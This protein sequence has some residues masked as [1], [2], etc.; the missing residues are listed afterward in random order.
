MEMRAVEAA[1]RDAGRGGARGAGPRLGQGRKGARNGGGGLGRG[2]E[3]REE[4]KGSEERRER[5]GRGEPGVGGKEGKV[6]RVGRGW[7]EGGE[8]TRRPLVGPLCTLCWAGEWDAELEHKVTRGLEGGSY[9]RVV[10]GSVGG[11][12]LP[13]W[14]RRGPWK[15]GAICPVGCGYSRPKEWCD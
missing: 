2:G 1:P 14:R 13:G 12:G 5:G 7:T 8:A 10:M 3:G 9:R 4:R 6:G 11:R 15:M